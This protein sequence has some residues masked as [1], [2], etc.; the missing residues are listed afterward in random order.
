LK[1]AEPA[2]DLAVEQVLAPTVLASHTAS[3]ALLDHHDRPPDV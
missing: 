2:D 1:V 3:G